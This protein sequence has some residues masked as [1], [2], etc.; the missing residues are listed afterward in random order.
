L[1]FGGSIGRQRRLK[2]TQCLFDE[3]F[4]STY[5]AANSTDLATKLTKIWKEKYCSAA[6]EN[7]VKKL[8]SWDYVIKKCPGIDKLT[9]KA[10]F[11]FKRFLSTISPGTATVYI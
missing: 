4:L 8:K 5:N 11:D 6:C 1:L 2:I 7:A 10:P 9:S 3:S